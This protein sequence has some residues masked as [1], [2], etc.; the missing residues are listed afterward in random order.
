MRSRS[1]VP[2][3]APSERSGSAISAHCWERSAVTADRLCRV[4]R[5]IGAGALTALALVLLSACGSSSV[6]SKRTAVVARTGSA[7]KVV[8]LLR[9]A[10]PDPSAGCRGVHRLGGGAERIPATVSDKHGQVAVLVNVCIQGRGPFPFVVDTGAS[11]TAVDAGLVKRLGLTEVGQPE[12]LMG[13]GCVTDGQEHRV[14]RWS[15]AGLPLAPQTLTAVKIPEMGGPGEPVGVIGSDV[16]N[17]FGA[18]R[19]DFRRRDLVVP[20][21][22]RAAPRRA[23]LITRPTISQLPASLIRGAAQFDAPMTVNASPDTVL[24]GTVVA[25]GSHQPQEFI[26]D[27]GAVISVVDSAEASL[28]GLKRLDQRTTQSTICSVNTSPDVLTG[29]WSI[30]GNTFSSASLAG[31]A[32]APQSVATMDLGGLRGVGGFLGADQMSRFG[33]VVFDYSG[34]RILLGAH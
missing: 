34:G 4:L 33:S 18:L 27:T 25:F 22:E 20:G 13:P 16:F 19:I 14:A 31:Q 32:L 15:I 6:A 9:L 7:G 8:P 30:A 3:R 21:R 29:P 17:R 11:S 1:A 28:M 10:L 23:V 12:K 2:R 26:P 5:V 24:I